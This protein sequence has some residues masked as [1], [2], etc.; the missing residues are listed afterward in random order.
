[1][2][3]I[4]NRIII[5]KS[6]IESCEGLIPLLK[7]HNFDITASPKNGNSLIEYIKKQQ[8]SVVICDAF[9]QNKDA[10]TVMSEIK[11]LQEINQIECS[12]RFIIV[13]QH[14]SNSFLEEQI[15]NNGASYLMF[16][17]FS[18]ESLVKITINLMNS[19]KTKSKNHKDHEYNI[20][21][22]ITKMIQEIGVPAHIKGYSYIRTGI[23]Y[24]VENNSV[25]GS[26]TKILY[27]RIAAAYDTTPSRVERAIRHAIEVAWD[28]GDIEILN[29][30]FG[31][32]IKG[33][34]GK[35]TNSE[36]IAMLA[37]KIKLQHKSMNLS[38]AI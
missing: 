10:I 16:K 28:R 25:L 6:C 12:P 31:Y 18:T 14:S 37:D 20:E 23:I 30:Y 26:V 4:S 8:P 15:M 2:E 13:T 3:N 32:T 19:P 9:M 27:P 11:E 7:D 24:C 34:K 22:E 38:I 33:S 36:F 21:E 17:P 1:M 29:S 35:P 5:C